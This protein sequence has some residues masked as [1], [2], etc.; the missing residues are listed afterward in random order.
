MEVVTPLAERALRLLL[1]PP[2]RP[3]GLGRQVPQLPPQPAWRLQGLEL[4]GDGPG[5]FGVLAQVPD[6]LPAPAAEPQLETTSMSQRY[7]IS[8]AP[9]KR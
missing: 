5:A 8:R 2:Q 4:P 3:A 7:S 9:S 6:R 1:G